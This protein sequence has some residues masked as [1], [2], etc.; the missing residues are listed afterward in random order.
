MEK[1]QQLAVTL[2][3]EIDSLVLMRNKAVYELAKRL[4][5]VKD[6]NYFLTLGY[7]SFDQYAASKKMRPKTARAYVYIY[8]LFILKF[9]YQ[10]HE[11]ANTP[12]YRLQLIAPKIKEEKKEVVDEWIGKAQELS[13]GDLMLE[14]KEHDINKDFENKVAYPQLHRCKKCGK[15]VIKD[16]EVCICK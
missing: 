2:D 13:P 14:L 16:I 15:F 11:L 10:E 1:K 6:E 7:D 3:S 12:W 8:E 5:A 9:G 4:K